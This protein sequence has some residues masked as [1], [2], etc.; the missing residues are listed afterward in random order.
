MALTLN[1]T[2]GIS[3]VDGSASAPSVVGSDSNTGISFASDTLI[4]NTAGT[5]RGRID[6]GG[7]LLLG[8]T[9]GTSAL[10]Q[11][12]EGAQV[13]GA[14]NDGNSSC[15]TLDYSG[16]TGRVMAHGSGGGTLAFFANGSSGGVQER[17][18]I[19]TNGSVFAVGIYNA[20]TGSSADGVVVSSGGK[21]RRVTSSQRY[22]TSVETLEDK[23]ADAIL[24]VRPVWYKSL[25]ED[26][27]KDYG[28]WGFI[29]EEIEKIDPRLCAYKSSEIVIEDGVAVEKKL[30]TPIVESVQYER[31]VPHLI[32][33]VKRQDTRIKALE[34]KVAALEAA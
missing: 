19:D 29:A 15:L 3:G 17:M 28:H 2:T 10:L 4:L 26:D 9:S 6:S 8:K 1:G 25:C 23:Y 11:V 24:E 27:N 20:T 30:D 33:L 22:K 18:K 7:R 21:L 34:T 14:A 16:T 5:E 32:N 13:F 12:D 31:F